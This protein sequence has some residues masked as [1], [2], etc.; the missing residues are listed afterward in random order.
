MTFHVFLPSCPLLALL[1]TELAALHTPAH[2]AAFIPCVCL[3]IHVTSPVETSWNGL[4][5]TI[6]S[7]PGLSENVLLHSVGAIIC[8]L[9]SLIMNISRYR[10]TSLRSFFCLSNDCYIIWV[11][12]KYPSNN[13]QIFL[14]IPYFVIPLCYSLNKKIICLKIFS[15][16]LS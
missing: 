9:F 8:D 5:E 12:N 7:S 10:I 4:S 11:P 1:F 14:P 2:N 15:R 6:F 16:D 3:I 13:D